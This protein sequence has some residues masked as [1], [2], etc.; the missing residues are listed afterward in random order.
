MQWWQV[1]QGG[2][3][4]PLRA[5]WATAYSWRPAGSSWGRSRICLPGAWGQVAVPLENVT[6][7]PSL[8]SITSITPYYCPSQSPLHFH[9]LT[10]HTGGG[11]WIDIQALWPSFPTPFSTQQLTWEKTTLAKDASRR[12]Y[13]NWE[14]SRVLW[15]KGPCSQ[16]SSI[17]VSG[18][19]VGRAESQSV[20]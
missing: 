17:S 18:A 2:P 6:H 4:E 3:L 5:F 11:N 20:I 1:R 7:F 10:W 15:H 12:N 13:L 19:H 9:P 8:H 16:T 14:E